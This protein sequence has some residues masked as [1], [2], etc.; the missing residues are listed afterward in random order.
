MSDAK[1]D[2]FALVQRLEPGLNFGHV[3]KRLR[4]QCQTKCALSW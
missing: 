1:G 4:R 3:R 2:V